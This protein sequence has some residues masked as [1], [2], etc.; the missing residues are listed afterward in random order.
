MKDIECPY[1]EKWFDICNDDGHGCDPLETYE[2]QCPHCEKKFTFTVEW[3][4]TYEAEKADCLNGGE[5]EWKRTNA[6]PAEY[7]EMRC[8][9]CKECRPCTPEEAAAP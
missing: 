4:P 2:D 9:G 5:H 1:C 7:R 8:S 3:S 6:I